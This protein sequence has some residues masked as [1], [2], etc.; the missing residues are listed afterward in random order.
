[1]KLKLT[2]AILAFLAFSSVQAQTDSFN[3]KVK[4]LLEL[5]GGEASFK[6]AIQTMMGQIRLTRSEV[7]GEVWDELEGEFMATS[8]DDLVAMIAPIYNKHLTEAD[9]DSIIGFYNTP[10]GKKFG[11]KTPL[12]TQES[13]QAGQQ[14]GMQ[15]GQ[16]LMERLQEKGY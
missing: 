1:M 7:P 9:L 16:K 4:T 6:G 3:K 5:S 15:I 8:M 10:A 12:I 11:E 2:F 13:M 14:W